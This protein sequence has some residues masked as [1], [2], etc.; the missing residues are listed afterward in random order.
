MITVVSEASLSAV[1]I[2]MI[3]VGATILGSV[4]TILRIPQ[5]FADLVVA[6]S[7]PPWGVVILMCLLLLVLGMFLECASITLITVPIFYPAM[8]ALG[9]HPLWFAVVFTINMELA[10]ITPPVGLNLYVIK[11][12]TDEKMETVI[13]GAFQFV[14]LLAVGLLIIALIEPMSTWLPST[15]I[16]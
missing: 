11:G 8:V 16:R 15:M 13:R 14:I 6:S 12:I 2:L 9:Y 3:I 1:M 5:N 10:L 7:I 4:L